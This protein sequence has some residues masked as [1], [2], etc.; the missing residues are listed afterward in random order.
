MPYCC[1]LGAESDLVICRMPHTHT[2][3]CDGVHPYRVTDI[4]APKGTSDLTVRIPKGRSVMFFFPLTVVYRFGDALPDMKH[5]YTHHMLC[6]PAQPP[7]RCDL[8][9]SLLEKN[10][11]EFAARQEWEAEWNQF[12]LASR[13]S[14]EVSASYYYYFCLGMHGTSLDVHFILVGHPYS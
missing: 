5:Y 7:V 3:G 11:S 14:E 8:L 4:Q 9:T 2:Q 1:Y 10:A 6:V 13:L 12:G